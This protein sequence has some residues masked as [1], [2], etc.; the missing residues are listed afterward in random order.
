[1]NNRKQFDELN[2]KELSQLLSDYREHKIITEYGYKIPFS[3]KW[4]YV[5]KHVG[6][7]K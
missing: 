1:M 2:S 4:F 5:S 3:I 6:F 7:Y